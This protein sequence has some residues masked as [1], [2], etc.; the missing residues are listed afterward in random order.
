MFFFIILAPGNDVLSGHSNAVV[1]K[2]LNR[3]VFFN[4]IVHVKCVYGLIGEI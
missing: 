1:P 4:A 2:W 3:S